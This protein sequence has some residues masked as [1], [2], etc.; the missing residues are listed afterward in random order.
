MQVWSFKGLN[1]QHFQILCS[2]AADTR[3]SVH[4]STYCIF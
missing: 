1:A 3:D 2:T 4:S